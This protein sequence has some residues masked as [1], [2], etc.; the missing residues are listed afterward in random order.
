MVNTRKMKTLV[1]G[2]KNLA[3]VSVI[4]DLG[5]QPMIESKTNPL[6]NDALVNKGKCIVD[7]FPFA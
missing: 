6:D 5:V 3:L 7:S 1:N 4:Q 2:S